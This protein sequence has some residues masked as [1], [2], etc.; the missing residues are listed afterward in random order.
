MIKT[1][2]KEDICDKAIIT[3]SRLTRELLPTSVKSATI[4]PLLIISFYLSKIK[5]DAIA[6]A[7]AFLLKGPINF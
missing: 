1:E 4:Y 2:V 5:A 6:I 7:S 3:G